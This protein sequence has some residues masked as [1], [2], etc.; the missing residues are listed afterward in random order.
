MSKDIDISDVVT[1]I[2]EEEKPVSLD[3][4]CKATMGYLFKELQDDDYR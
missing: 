4:L 3:E 2:I 1:E